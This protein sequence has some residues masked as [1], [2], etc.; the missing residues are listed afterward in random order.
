[1]S[2]STLA[3]FT[4]LALLG[5]GSFG[6]VYKVKRFKDQK[7]YVMKQIR[8]DDMTTSE[9]REAISECNIM[10]SL[11][12]THICKYYDSFID[13]GLLNIVMEFCPHGDLQQMLS[14][15]KATLDDV[16]INS[17]NYLREP[18]VWKYLLE[19]A[20]GLFYM[21]HKKVIHRDLKSA[22]IF[23]GTGGSVK[24]GDLGVAKRLDNT[25]AFAES[26]VG[27]PYYLSP[28]LCEKRPYN[29]LSDI[30][31][32]GVIL[33]ELMTFKHPFDAKNHAALIM[34]IL[35]GKYAPPPHDVYSH[36]LRLVLNGLLNRDL[37]KR[38]TLK[39][40]FRLKCVRN[41][42]NKI[43]MDL[44]ATMTLVGK[45]KTS[46]DNRDHKIGIPKSRKAKPG[47]TTSDRKPDTHQSVLFV[48]R[49]SLG[50]QGNVRGAR[51]RG[52]L[53]AQNRTLAPNLERTPGRTQHDGRPSSSEAKPNESE[54]RFFEAKAALAPHSSS[55]RSPGPIEPNPHQGR[56]KG[57]KRPTVQQLRNLIEE[58]MHVEE[59][60]NSGQGDDEL[61]DDRGDSPGP[62]PPPPPRSGEGKASDFESSMKSTS[63]FFDTEE[64]GFDAF[65]KICFNEHADGLEPELAGVSSNMIDSSEQMF[66]GSK[67]FES[68]DKENTEERQR[69]PKM[70]MVGEEEGGAFEGKV[71]DYGSGTASS[72]SSIGGIQNEH[73]LNFSIEYQI[74]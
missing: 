71:R 74:K 42:A 45:Y 7:E 66:V 72:T 40:L 36:D 70:K 41:W 24:I 63:V 18:Q 43:G 58:T 37:K 34:K 1:M 10:A 9:Q 46:E 2:K 31:A 29:R 26:F 21:H 25:N 57:S 54:G 3:D 65:D 14:K 33:Y 61:A 38:L 64:E 4:D 11:K 6:E 60:L 48:R 44:S 19:I 59:V 32:L 35:H 62:P 56:S 67:T 5:R 17:R 50:L 49:K 68:Y 13:S 51:V 39:K 73:R 23:L 55:P 28:E 27:T 12:H 52:K 16:H 69:A 20:S 53:K 47:A 22:N 15:H 8:V 30:W